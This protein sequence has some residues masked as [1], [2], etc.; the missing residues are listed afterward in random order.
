MIKSD[1]NQADGSP[2][3]KKLSSKE[4]RADLNQVIEICKKRERKEGRIMV[5]VSSTPPTWKLIDAHKI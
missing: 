1:T 4:N 3:P 2:R 5:K